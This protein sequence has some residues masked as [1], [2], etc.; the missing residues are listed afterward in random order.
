[1]SRLLSHMIIP[2][3][4]SKMVLTPL[5]FI[6]GLYGCKN[7]LMNIAQNNKIMNQR[8]SYL[9]DLRNHG[10]SFHSSNMDV[11]VTLTY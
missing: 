3:N 11:P 2:D 4:A 6:H 7:N 10:N 9:F 5:I 1:M 8:I